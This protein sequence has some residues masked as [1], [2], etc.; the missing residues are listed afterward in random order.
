MKYLT[1]KNNDE[2]LAYIRGKKK[3]VEPRRV[4]ASKAEAKKEV[5]DEVR[6]DKADKDTAKSD[7]PKVG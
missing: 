3:F 2:Y 1:F 7:S 6:T 4:A 5:S